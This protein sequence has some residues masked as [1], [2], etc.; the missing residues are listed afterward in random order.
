MHPSIYR[1]QRG[2]LITYAC[3]SIPVRH[4]F[5]TKYGGVS[6][7]IF[8]SL[9]LGFHRG[10]VSDHVQTN[11]RLL[12]HGLEV[13]LARMT[14]TKQIHDTQVAVVGEAEVGMGLTQ[15]MAW[16]ADAIVT[17]LPDTPLLGF[18]ADCIVALFYD[19]S[20]HSIGVCHAGWRGVAGGIL[21][22]TADTMA[23][24]LGA[25]REHMVV[26]LGP[27][28]RQECF[29]TDADVPTAMEQSLGT[30]LAPFVR[31][32]G[33][34][35][36]VDLQGIALLQLQQAGL[37]RD[38]LIDSGLCTKCCHDTFWSHRYTNGQR[39]VHA[40]LICLPPHRA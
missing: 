27:S 7:G 34:K 35:F 10:D 3:R 29:E 12:A 5:T 16:E 25:R 28:I 23:A 26:V 20:S 40:G 36:H 38:N 1:V 13:P 18:Y 11:Y 24:K 19:P 2:N 21:P 4:A 14:L 32:Q 31:T 37:H 33:E 6:E 8:E 22:K 30:A 15:A 9:N 17:A 39:G